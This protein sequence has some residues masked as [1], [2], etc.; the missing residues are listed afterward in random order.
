MA[1][2]S[3]PQLI[4]LALG[5]GVV[6]SFLLLSCQHKIRTDQEAGLT[7]EISGL[8]TFTASWASSF[9]ATSFGSPPPSW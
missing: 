3:G 9:S 2:I 5:F 8:G 4:P 1:L 7:T 6:G